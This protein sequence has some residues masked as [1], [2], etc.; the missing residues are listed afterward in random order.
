M[1]ITLTAR[2]EPRAVELELE[3]RAME[4]EPRQL[5]L[6]GSARSTTAMGTTDYTTR[7]AESTRVLTVAISREKPTVATKC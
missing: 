5:K 1:A 7:L 6:A 2:S 3:S 4:P